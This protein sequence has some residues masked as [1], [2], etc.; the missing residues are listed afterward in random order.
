MADAI[1]PILE[2]EEEREEEEVE[3][4][5]IDDE[6]VSVVEQTEEVPVL[7]SESG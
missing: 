7:G 2:E 4:E 6:P 1:C 3:K 5:V